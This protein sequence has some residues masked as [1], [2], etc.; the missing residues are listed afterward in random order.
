MAIS[1][2]EPENLTDIE[3]RALDQIA[4]EPS[5][6]DKLFGVIEDKTSTEVDAVIRRPQGPG[7]EWVEVFRFPIHPIEKEQYERAQRVSVVGHDRVNGRRVDRNDQDLFRI[8]LIYE[9][10][11]DEARADYWDNKEAWARANVRSY[12]DLIKKTFRPGERVYLERLI[13]RISG[14]APEDETESSDP[15]EVAGN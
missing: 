8:Q 3:K 5:K 2:I 15:E 12:I 9:A 4:S 1:D 13:D 6:L 11:T 7:G 14:F 10:S